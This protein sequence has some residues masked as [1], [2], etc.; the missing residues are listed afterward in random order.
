MCIRDRY[1]PFPEDLKGKYQEHTEAD[2]TNLRG[3]GYDNIFL[4]L[5]EGLERYFKVLKSGG[6]LYT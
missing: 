2:L 3:A 1:V 6:G 4:M 5:E